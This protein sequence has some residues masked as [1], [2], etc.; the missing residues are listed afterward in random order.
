MYTVHLAFRAAT[1]VHLA[2]RAAT[3]VHLAFR[4]ATTGS[5]SVLLTV[6]RDTGGERENGLLEK[7]GLYTPPHTNRKD[8]T[9]LQDYPTREKPVGCNI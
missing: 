5:G 6:L 8:K 9:E 3:T 2:F 7:P 1:T 4:A